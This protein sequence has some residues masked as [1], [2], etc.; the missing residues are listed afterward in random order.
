MSFFA[1][2]GRHRTPSSFSGIRVVRAGAVV[3]VSA[4]FAT[5][6]VVPANANSAGLEEADT[7]FTQ[8]TT[9]WEDTSQSDTWEDSSSQTA[10]ATYSEPERG[11]QGASRSTERASVASASGSAIT[12][13]AQQYTGIMYRWGG[14]TPAGFD[15]SGYT[16]YV[17]GQAGISLP[18]T[19]EGQR[20]A[21]TPVSSPQ[22]GDLVFWGAPAYH[23][24]IYA[25][26]GM[27]YDSGRAGLPSQLRPMFSGVTSFGSIG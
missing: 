3:A 7:T 19:A 24:A 16:Q 14:S 12:A 5:A 21:S 8:E 20:Q 13:N 27:I 2:P 15:C 10:S 18:R 26:D 23:V 1:T 4:G 11:E 22:P 6:A 9:T 17:Y 25:G